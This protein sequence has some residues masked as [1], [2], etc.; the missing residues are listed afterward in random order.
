MIPLINYIVDF[1]FPKTCIVT[2]NRLTDNNSNNYVED[3]VMQSIHKVTS[4]ELKEMMSKVKSDYAYTL[5]NFTED[6]PLQQIIHHFKYRGMKKLGIYLGEI[7][8]KEIINNTNDIVKT[9]DIIIPVPLFKT[10]ERERGYNQAEYL[11]KGINNILQIEFIKDLVKRIRHTK[12]Q[13]KL[14]QSERI[15]NV[16]DAFEINKNY[17]GKISGKRIIL[18]DDVVTTGSTLNE[19]IKVLRKEDVSQ[20]FILTI[21]M[22]KK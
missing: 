17:E 1:I 20:I 8:G 11:C 10:K 15:E 16:K 13:T 4:D 12:S 14:S 22:A 2:G 18:V 5:Y 19:I 3:E 9:F 7:I 6:S 21:A